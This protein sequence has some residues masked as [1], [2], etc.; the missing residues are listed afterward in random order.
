MFSLKTLLLIEIT[1]NR[2]GEKNMSV[3]M[4]IFLYSYTNNW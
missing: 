3:K 4:N 1:N 2:R